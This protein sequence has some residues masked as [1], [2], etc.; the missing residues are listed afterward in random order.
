MPN[1]IVNTDGSNNA[2]FLSVVEERGHHIETVITINHIEFT[3]IDG[4][5]KDLQ[6]GTNASLANVKI[7]LV[8]TSLKTTPAENSKVV[9]A[10]TGAKEAPVN[11]N[12]LEFNEDLI[13]I[14]NM[15]YD[16]F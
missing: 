16:L 3:T 9:F 13:V 10:L 5:F 15:T 14:H 2:I 7:S 12:D 1:A 6:I 8:T 11:A 4:D